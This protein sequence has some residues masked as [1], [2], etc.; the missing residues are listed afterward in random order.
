MQSKVNVDDTYIRLASISPSAC[1]SLVLAAGAADAR[2][3]LHTIN[4]STA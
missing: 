3:R 1:Q 2:S 4:D